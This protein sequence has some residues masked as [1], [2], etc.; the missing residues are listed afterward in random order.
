MK[1]LILFLAVFLFA[2]PLFTINEYRNAVRLNPLDENPSLTLAAKWH[3]K[4]IYANNEI[5][6]IQR[7]YG[8]YFSGKTPADR[9]ISCGYESRYVIENLSRGEKSYNESIKDLFGAIYHRFGFLNFNINEIGYYKLNDIYVYNMGNSFI[10]RACKIKSDYK[11]GFAG[12]C[13][14]KNKIIPKGVYYDQMKTNPQMVTWP[15]DGM[16]NTPAV[17]YE[18]IPDPLP[19][20]GVCGYP[21]SISFNPYYYENKKISLISFE[22]YKNGKKVEKTKIITYKNDVNRMLKKT[23]FV[24]FPLERLEYGAHYDVKADFIINGRM[25]SFEW[26]FDVEEKRIPVITV[27]GTNGKYFIKSNITYLIYFKPLNSNDRLSGLKYEY[28]KGL[29]IN[30]IG[31]KDANTIYLNISGYP[32]KK[33]KITTKKRKIILVIKD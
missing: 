31:Y 32:G 13:R 19:E 6:H 15:Y 3:A 23:Q 21:V 5:T 7:K 29:K 11:S 20:Y 30:K 18:E 1:K 10:N 22:L 17:F 24:L 14:D 8:R 26:G 9:A 27:I 4:Y 28:I 33:L 12:L 16:K 2:N 25:K